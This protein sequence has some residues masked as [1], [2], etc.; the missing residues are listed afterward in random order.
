MDEGVVV[1]L[2]LD[3]SRGGD[4]GIRPRKKTLWYE[5]CYFVLVGGEVVTTGIVG[6]WTNRSHELK[7][8][9]WHIIWQGHSLLSRGCN[10]SGILLG[11]G[12]TCLMEPL[13][14]G[15]VQQHRILDHLEDA[16][17]EDGSV[18][19]ARRYNCKASLERVITVQ[20]VKL[21]KAGQVPSVGDEGAQAMEGGPV[22]AEGLH[23]TQQRQVDCRPLETECEDR[24]VGSCVPSHLFV[25]A[26]TPP[27]QLADAGAW[28]ERL[29]LCSSTC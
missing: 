24:V 2:D 18:I 23:S 20:D 12:T 22:D 26:S 14:V 7:N 13:D 9:V 3:I 4:P 8:N 25:Q 29:C 6:V 15:V 28:E 21:G 17:P 10:L 27:V 11:Q 5:C 16:R 1:K 19:G